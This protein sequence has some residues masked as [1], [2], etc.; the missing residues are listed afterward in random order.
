MKNVR[1]N[2]KSKKV[3]KNRKIHKTRKTRKTR[4]YRGGNSYD[5]LIKVV[6]QPYSYNL[7]VEQIKDDVIYE[8]ANGL[9]TGPWKYNQPY[10]RGKMDVLENNNTT[11][12]KGTYDGPWMNGKPHGENCKYTT[13]SGNIY[14]GEYK[15]GLIDGRGI[16]TYANGIKY[17]GEFKNGF[18]DGEGT[19][20]YN[21][22][23]N[24]TGHFVRNERHGYGVLTY[25]NGTIY[26][27]QWANNR[28]NGIGTFESPIEVY[29]GT[30]V[31]DDPNGNGD[32]TFKETKVILKGKFSYDRQTNNM[33]VKGIAKY[34]D[35][36][37]Y[38]GM[39]NNYVKY[40]E[41]IAK[42]AGDNLANDA[43]YDIRYGYVTDP[44]NI[45]ANS[46]F[47]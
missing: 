8:K 18:M 29:T 24:Y 45:T 27:G 46:D 20:T 26:K 15:D 36:S 16:F 5:S 13:V 22:G 34:Q 2:E 19:A 28:K 11:T 35:D 1:K 4:K 42:P 17:D 37:T 41:G 44:N 7:V 32:I 3:K 10:M 25:S 30:W 31:N 39:F 43:N 9:Y 47:F 38:E 40:G 12:I 21:N 14:E 23:S 6:N 33:V